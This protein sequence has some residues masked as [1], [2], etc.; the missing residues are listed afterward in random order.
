MEKRQEFSLL[1]K[2]DQ[3]MVEIFVRSDQQAAELGGEQ[4]AGPNDPGRR[5]EVLL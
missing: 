2:L 3:V 4:I 5:A 1:E